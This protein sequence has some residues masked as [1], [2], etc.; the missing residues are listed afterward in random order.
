MA[1]DY[2]YER[3]EPLLTIKDVSVSFGDKP[4]LKDMSAQILN[5][6]RP[7][8]EQGQVVGLLGPSG[9]GKT[10]LF[11]VLAGL[12]KPDK[13]HVLIGPSQIPTSPGKVGVVA[14]NYPLIR[15]RTVGG[16]LELAGKLAGLNAEQIEVKVVAYLEEF[17]LLE[18]RHKYPSQLS[19]GQRQRVAIAQQLICSEYYLIMDEPF[20][21]LDVNSLDK[22]QKLIHR[23][24]AAHE[25]VTIVVVTHDVSA[26]VAVSDTIWLMG[27]DRTPDGEIIPGARIMETYDLIERGLTWRPDLLNMSEATQLIREIKDRF[28][29]L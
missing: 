11:R 28:A 5:I 2:S 13:G 14:Q 12:M 29:T 7:G 18:H 10:T 27:R 8:H 21:G 25:E 24:S 4:I 1:V 26:A 3:K 20:S 6:V 15:H 22:V 16:N 9:I 17:G 23:V 19:G